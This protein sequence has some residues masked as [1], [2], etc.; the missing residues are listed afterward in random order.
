[1]QFT[2][3]ATDRHTSA[4]AGELLTDHGA[5][6][7]PI[8]MPVGTAAT[9]KSIHPRE[10][11]E[12]VRAQIVLANTYHLFVRP[13]IDVVEAAGGVQEFSKWR[14]PMLTDSGGYQ[15]YSLANNRKLS[16]GGAT[17]RNHVNG[18]KTLFTPESVMDIQRRIGAD[19]VMA[20]D[21]CPPYPSTHAYAKTSMEL[22]HRWLDRCVERF[23]ASACPHGYTQALFP[24]LQGSTYADL[25]RESAEYIAGKEL[26][27][28]AIGGL[29]VGEPITEMYPTVQQ[30]CE[31]LPAG[32]PRYLMGV[33]TPANLVECIARGVDMFDCVL[34]SRNGRHGH[35]YTRRG[36]MNMR[37][38]RWANDHTPLDA[39]S[40]APTSRLHS[41]AYVRHLVNSGESLGGQLCTLHNLAFF[42]WLVGEAR[43]RILDGNFARWRTA[44]VP[45]LVRKL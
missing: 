3:Q 17:F 5:V 30:V 40:T 26:P 41:R 27:G 4:R 14:G 36:L 2:L 24:I 15:V 21:E 38:S 25:R 35:I 28:N 23:S 44:I 39:E 6:R 11:H 20:F 43:Q 32:K 8:F 22:T 18:D 16:E 45:D 12:D 34:P 31:I 10:L 19:I 13:G 7:T 42:L 9:V 1:M 29:S 33:G 37:N